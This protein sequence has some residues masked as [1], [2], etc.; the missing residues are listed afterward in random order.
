MTNGKYKCDSF[1]KWSVSNLA[2]KRDLLVL[3]E[4]P[5]KITI[6]S[7]S[8]YPERMR[9]KEKKKGSM[10]KPIRQ[11]NKHNPINAAKKK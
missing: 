6:L 8:N 4:N 9:V 11:Q 2:I 7:L 10:L 3:R 1:L 5:I